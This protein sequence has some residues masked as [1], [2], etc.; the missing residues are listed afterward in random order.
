MGLS[1]AHQPGDSLGEP[2]VW[3]SGEV[4]VDAR[5]VRVEWFFTQDEYEALGRAEAERVAVAESAALSARLSR[6]DGHEPSQPVAVIWRGGVARPVVAALVAA[7]LLLGVVVSPALAGF[8]GRDC[9]DPV[10]HSRAW[11]REHWEAWCRAP[12]CGTEEEQAL[13][14]LRAQAERTD[15]A[16]CKAA[17]F[18]SEQ[19]GQKSRGIQWVAARDMLRSLPRDVV[20]SAVRRDASAFGVDPDDILE[21]LRGAMDQ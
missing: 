8:T 19:Y 1:L 12:W 10:A 15:I 13:A 11:T 9:G 3:I 5:I 14:F 21:R 7:A 20:V 16:A 18:L 2:G 4:L 17:V 6:E